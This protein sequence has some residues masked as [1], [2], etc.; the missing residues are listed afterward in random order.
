MEERKIAGEGVVTGF[1]KVEGNPVALFAQDFT[2]AGGS[3]GEAY[4]GKII[5]I[6]DPAGSMGTPLTGI[7][8]F[9]HDSDFK[10]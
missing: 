9:S 8:A 2:V 3:L 4:A 7:V 10:S 5:K 6:M 1:G